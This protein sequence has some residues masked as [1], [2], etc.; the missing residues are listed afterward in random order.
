MPPTALPLTPRNVERYG[1]TISNNGA[2]GMIVNIGNLT[3]TSDT[4][5]SNGVHGIRLLN[6]SIA[7]VFDLTINGNSAV[8]IH[9]EPRPP[10]RLSR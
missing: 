5:T 6:N 3:A 2:S 8:G 10:P 7:R 9:L 4:I 1:N